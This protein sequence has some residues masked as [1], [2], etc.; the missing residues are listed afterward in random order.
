MRNVVSIASLLPTNKPMCLVMRY[1]KSIYQVLAGCLLAVAF[2]GS[3]RAQEAR[4]LNVGPMRYNTNEALTDDSISW[5]VD[6][7]VASARRAMLDANTVIVGVERTWTDASGV[8]RDIQ[9]A[10]IGR[11]KFSDIELVTPPVSGAF[12]RTYRTPYPSKVLDGQEWTSIQAMGDPVDPNLPADAVIYTHLNSWTGIDIERWGYAF[13]NDDHDDYIIMEYRFTNTSGEVRNNVYF[14][15]QAQTHASAYYPA[16]L[17]GNYYGATYSGFVAGDQDADSL[18]LWYSWDGDQTSNTAVDTRGKPHGQ[19]GHF[20][21]S[22]FFGHVVLHADTSPADETD[23]P[24]QPVK[25]GWSQRE[26]A[27][28]LNVAGHE[29][30]YNYLS[31][32]WD[33]ANPGAYSTTV[34][35]T[36][37]IVSEGPYRILNRGLGSTGDPSVDINNTTQFDPLTEQEKTSLFSFGPYTL[38]PGD[39]IRIVTAYV[40]GVIPYRWAIDAGAAYANGNPQQFPLAPLPYTLPN[41]DADYLN[42]DEMDA[43]RAYVGGQTIVSQGGM[44]D[45][46]TKNEVLDLGRPLLFMNAAKA[47]RTWRSGN[48]K[49]GQGSFDIPLAPATPA[50]TGSSG[51]D[52]VRLD[53]GNEAAEDNRAGVITGYR[54]YRELIRPAALEA[55]TDTTFLLHEELPAGT[56]EYV[57]TRVTRGEDY[58]YYVVAVNAD[59]VESSRFL[60]RTGTTSDKFLEALT[61]TRSPDANWQ[62]NVVVVPNPYHAQGAYNYE[63]ARRLTFL[64]LPAYANIHIYTVTGDRVQTIEHVSNTG[65]DDWERQ[66]TFS[67]TQIVSGVYIYVVEELS[68]PGGG[69]TGNQ[70]IGKFVVI[71]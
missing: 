7:P 57:D 55:P 63:E 12:K 65:D 49:Y 18:R 2:S 46:S 66:E 56:R 67:T 22:Q 5:P 44:L 52:Q 60:N 68:V 8:V 10:Q 50:L 13:A 42:P 15:L 69:A 71:K 28:D 19:W 3:V 54:I 24:V 70:A 43:I 16:D 26:L 39:D 64:N 4:S 53:W 47:V 30:I 31:K 6:R 36:G 9:V 59:G 29:D 45:K 21:E 40:G 17:W 38:N 37:A 25:A 23:N 58:Y 34:D 11:R 35:H 1:R 61:P 32:G 20:Q 51:N 33:S 41:Y 62:A 27:P 14:G 48:V